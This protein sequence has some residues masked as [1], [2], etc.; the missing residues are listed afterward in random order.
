LEERRGFEYERFIE[1]GE[2]RVIDGQFGG[3]EENAKRFFDKMS[4]ER[5]DKIIHLVKKHLAIQNKSLPPEL[6]I[7]LEEFLGLIGRESKFD[8]NVVSPMN[9][10]GL[11]QLMPATAKFAGIKIYPVRKGE[12][13]TRENNPNIF[14]MEQN[15]LGGIK[16]LKFYRELFASPDSSILS[17]NVGIVRVVNLIMEDYPELRSASG[18]FDRKKYNKMRSEGAVGFLDLYENVQE[19]EPDKKS[20]KSTGF[21]YVQEVYGMEELV[22]KYWSSY[23]HQDKKPIRKK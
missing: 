22:K 19:E 21:N 13:F 11:C 9:A 20:W 6:K 23:L 1:Q 18:K 15:I 5:R 14:D 4:P 12:K 17:Y 16:S 10:C 8:P 2:K 3:S 7:T